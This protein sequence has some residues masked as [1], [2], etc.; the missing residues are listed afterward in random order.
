M[1]L[2]TLRIMRR[3]WAWVLAAVVVAVAT[4]VGAALVV[5][6]T[7]QSMAQVLFVPSVKQPG[8]AGPT[9]PFLSLGGSVAIVASLVQISVSDDQTA[10]QLMEGGFRADFEVTPN[11]NENAG[12]VLIITTED[13]SAEMAQRTLSAV[14]DAVQTDLR[15]LQDEQSVEQDLRVRAVVLTETTEPLV[16]RKTQIQV[17]VIAAGGVLLLSIGLLLLADRRRRTK[18]ARDREADVDE[19]DVRRAGDEHHE[20]WPSTAELE[21]TDGP[22]LAAA[23]GRR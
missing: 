17:A 23:R 7:Q 19:D 13:V 11:L 18:A 5:P 10:Q 1:L 6:P 3:L 20:H 8:V 12:P 4:G 2:E 16:L 14:V 15:S 9:N 22:P 21:A